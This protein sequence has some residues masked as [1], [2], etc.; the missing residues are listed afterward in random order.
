MP[1][2]LAWKISSSTKTAS[3]RA[4]KRNG[5]ISVESQRERE[6]E[7]RAEKEMTGDEKIEEPL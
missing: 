7:R 2:F 4:S 6:R 5:N 3:W 1:T